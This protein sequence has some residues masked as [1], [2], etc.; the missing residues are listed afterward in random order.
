MAPQTLIIKVVLLIRGRIPRLFQWV[1]SFGLK[2]IVGAGGV[3]AVSIG[4][5]A[6]IL[7]LV[8]IP[9][10]VYRWPGKLSQKTQ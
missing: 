6:M 5:F 3:V 1:V 9:L 8:L 4:A 10:L 2:K 7:T